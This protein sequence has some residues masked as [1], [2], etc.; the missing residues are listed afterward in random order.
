MSEHIGALRSEVAALRAE[1]VDKLGGQLRL[2][3]IETTRVIGSDLEALQH[4]IRRLAS[5]QQDDPAHGRSAPVPDSALPRVDSSVAGAARWRIEQ[6]A[7]IVDVE[8]IEGGQLARRR[9]E[10]SR[11]PLRRAVPVRPAGSGLVPADWVWQRRQARSV[12]AG[13]VVR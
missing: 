1:V 4:E 5:N 13:S 11:A 7:D 10:S 8:V 2:E 12:T 9:G 3:R 6:P